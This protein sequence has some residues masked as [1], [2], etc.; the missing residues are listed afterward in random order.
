MICLVKSISRHRQLFKVRKEITHFTLFEY[1]HVFSMYTYVTHVTQINT[2]CQGMLWAWPT[3]LTALHSMRKEIILSGIDGTRVD[4]WNVLYASRVLDVRTV[5]RHG[6]YFTNRYNRMKGVL[7]ISYPNNWGYLNMYMYLCIHYKTHNRKKTDIKA[8]SKGI[9]PRFLQQ[10]HIWL[11]T[12]LVR[13]NSSHYL[14][15]RYNETLEWNLFVSIMDIEQNRC[16]R[17][18]LSFAERKPRNNP[19]ICS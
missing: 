14:R 10:Y 18:R 19:E 17:P 1:F 3:R 13:L 15:S 11:L 9:Y 5:F 16:L 6:D 4:E 8:I 7:K 2:S 12:W